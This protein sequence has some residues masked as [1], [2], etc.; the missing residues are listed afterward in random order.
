M[1]KFI[2]LLLLLVSTQWVFAKTID[3]RDISSYPVGSDNRPL[4][5]GGFLTVYFNSIGRYENIPE[6]YQ[7][8]N[9]N[10]RN[11]K[12]DTPLYTA[13]QKG[14][15]MGFFKNL[16][17]DL[18]TKE[19]ATEEQFARAI[20]SNLGQKIEQV[21]TGTLSLKTV[22]DILSQLYQ[23]QPPESNNNT[24]ATIGNIDVGTFYPIS[25]VSNFAV[26]NDVYEKLKYNHYDSVKFHDEALI[27]GAAKGM[28]EASNDKHTAYFPPVESKNFQDQL[29]GEFEGIGAYIDMPK[30][31]ELHIISP[32]SGTPAEKSGLKWGDIITKIDDMSI[33]ESTALQDAIN[34]IKGV[35]GTTVKLHIKRGLE[36]LDFTITRA[37]ITINYV[38]YKKLDSG[39]QYIKITTFGAGVKDAFVQALTA[40]AKDSGNGKIIIDLRNNPGGSLDEVAGMLNYFVPKGQSVVH[41][42]YKNTVSEMQS[43]WQSL[44][45]LQRRKIVILINGGSASASEIMAGTIKDYLG[46][47]VRIIGE[48][49]YGKWSVQ[50]LDTYTDGSSFK[51]TIAKWF[52][53]K[54]QT[55]IDGMGIKPDIE[56][57]FDEKLWKDGRDN[58]MEYTKGLSW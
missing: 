28:A 7:Y 45:D 48:K 6:S 18:K 33:T 32:M 30:P 56:V 43:E 58:Q 46:E 47:N 57:K 11:V 17:I 4:N 5:F 34:K 24:G 10:F 37:K 2:I 13:L 8:I 55:G 26:L 42:K 52:T 25:T 1:K 44:I 22:L 53:G 41:I 35:G 29:G 36:E 14:V 16:P 21:G 27:Q 31:G 3:Y 12:K 50:S 23:E 39:E 9:L 40:V 49:S 51:Y 15:Y 54:T 19:F 20:E 38:E